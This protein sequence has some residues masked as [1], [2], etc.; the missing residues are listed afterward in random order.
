[1]RP[2]ISAGSHEPRLNVMRLSI[3][4][5]PS[6][7][8]QLP[9]V[10][11]LVSSR[12]IHR[13]GVASAPPNKTMVPRRQRPPRRP[14]VASIARCCQFRQ[15]RRPCAG[16]LA[17]GRTGQEGCSSCAPSELTNLHA[18]CRR[19]W[20]GR[21]E[22]KFKKGFS[23]L[24]GVPKLARHECGAYRHSPKAGSRPGTTMR[25]GEATS[26]LP[27]LQC[28]PNVEHQRRNN[29]LISRG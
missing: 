28:C 26:P 23:M 18:E 1:M 6:T 7:P 27:T 12:G 16:L 24:G 3:P 10:V 17:V 11:E 13:S 5:P 29:G 15:P 19:F 4:Y 2:P 22:D 25:S 9:D 20:N 8:R 14:S 21:T